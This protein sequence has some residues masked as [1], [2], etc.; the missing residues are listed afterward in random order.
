MK[1]L[2]PA[3]LAALVLLVAAPAGAH[4]GDAEMTVTSASRAGDDVDL[5][6]H[7][8]YVED[9]HGVPDA[10]VTAVVDGATPVTLEPAATE[11][12]YAGT[13]TAAP[14]TTIRI[15]SVEPTVTVEAEAPPAAEVPASS[16]EAAAPTTTTEAATTTTATEAPAPA[17]D[18]DGDDGS[19]LPAVV[20]GL[21]ALVVVAAVAV[22]TSRGRSRD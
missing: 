11:G 3:L 7:L 18:E 2:L 19:L 13:V 17:A 8:V 16:T 1:K 22:I 10:T 12:D 4:G 14:G 5:V 20:I 9:G 21:V 6:V 15:T